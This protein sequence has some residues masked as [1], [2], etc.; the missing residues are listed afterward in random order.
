MST[1]RAIVSLLPLLAPLVSS[2]PSSLTLT[3]S[4]IYYHSSK[5]Y[6][7]PAHLATYGGDIA[8]NVTSSDSAVPG[9]ARCSARGLHLNDFF[10]GELDYT[11]ET[12]LSNVVTNFTFSTPNS[13]FTINQTWT[14]DGNSYLAQGNGAADLDCERTFWQNDNWTMGQL[15]STETVDCEPAKLVITPTVSE[16]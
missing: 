10:Y 2:A 14:E 15:Y 13:M 16:I 8:F 6:S 1:I 4:D 9:I 12:V 5:V 11:C 7:T 3:L